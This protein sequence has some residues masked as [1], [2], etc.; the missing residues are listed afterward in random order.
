MPCSLGDLKKQVKLLFSMKEA[1]SEG[2]RRILSAMYSSEV[3]IS[4]ESL[5]DVLSLANQFQ[6]KGCLEAG[7][8]FLCNSIAQNNCLRYLSLAEKYELS[9]VVNKCEEFIEDNFETIS[10]TSEFNNIC[11]DKL[12]QLMS[13]KKLRLPS[14]E[15]EVYRAAMRWL[16]YNCESQTGSSGDVKLDPCYKIMGACKIPPNFTGSSP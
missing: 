8:K 13:D 4:D 11:L 6:M 15:I 5:E 12:C 3:S 10:K 2:L 9:K 7:E 1:S 14:G 16:E